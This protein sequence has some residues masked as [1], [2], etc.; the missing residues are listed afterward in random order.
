MKLY[1][2]KDMT[3]VSINGEEVQ[4]P[5]AWKGTDYALSYDATEAEPSGEP[6]V[7]VPEG[8][9]STDWT[10]KQ[11]QKYADQKGVEVSGNKAEM[12]AQLEKAAV[13]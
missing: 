12:V 7:A 8:A 2:D 1:T 6:E 9:P 11:L 3:T 13:I 5:K 4:V 10:Q